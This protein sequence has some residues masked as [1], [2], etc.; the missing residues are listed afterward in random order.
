MK[1][2]VSWL[3]GFL[4][5][6]LALTCSFVYSQTWEEYRK[7]EAEN[8]KKFK[9]DEEAY[10]AGMRKD[11]QDYVDKRDK[12]YADFLK[13]G[14]KPYKVKEPEKQPE[15]PK[16]V[17]VPEYVA[18]SVPP[19]ETYI[20][21][22][23]KPVVAAAP[24]QVAVAVPRPPVR[25]P[26]KPVDSA[27]PVSFRFYD[28]PVYLDYDRNFEV[29]VQPS[30][31][32][33]ISTYW[34]KASKT[35]YA[36]LVEQLLA[37]K[38]Q[39]N[40]N[41]YAYY[42]L[43]NK[44]AGYL[45]PT[46]ETGQTLATW[47]LMV[48]SGYGVRLATQGN[49]IVLLIPSGSAVYGKGYLTEDGMNYYIMNDVE[50]TSLNTY[51]K[52]YTGASRP[53]DFNI[54]SPID[55]GKKVS[56]KTLK[57]DYKGKQ[58][59]ILVSF[60]PGLIRLYNDFP[61]LGMDVYF[62]A[63]VSLQLKES[64]SAS[65]KP[66]MVGMNEA[67]SVEF[68]LAFVQHA[69]AY[70]TDPEQF[71]Y[72]KFFFA[73]EVFFYPFCDCED[74]S[75]LFSYLVRDLL[76][77]DVVGLEYPEHMA[78]AVCFTRQVPGDFV[79]Y[80]HRKFVVSDPTYIG[81]PVGRTMPNF[82]GIS[83]T[84][85]PMENVRGAETGMQSL[86][87]RVEEGGCFRGSNLH[88]TIGLSDGATLMTG[89]YSGS[90]NFCGKAL[91]ATDKVNGCFVGKVLDSGKPDWFSVLTST[92]NTVGVSIVAEEKGNIF[93]AGSF[94]GNLT[95]GSLSLSTNEDRPDGFVASYTPAG[96][97][98]W[99]RKLNLD[100]I[101]VTAPVA[102]SASFATDGKRMGLMQSE[103]F[104][105]FRDY[106]LFSD[107]SGKVV[108]N[109]IVNR[110]FATTPSTVS[111]AAGV[112]AASPELLKKETDAMISDRTDRG[113]A[114]LFAAINL[115]KDMVMVLSGTDAMAALDKFNPGFRTRSPSI[116]KNIG[117]IS[118]VRNSN[119]VIS[120]LTLDGK[121]IMFDKIKV[122]NKAQLSI[123]TLSSGD[124]QFDVLSGIKVGKMVVWYDLNFIR[125]S[126][127]NGDMMFDYDSDHSQQ[128]V[129]M[130]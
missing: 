87:S 41:D 35:Q 42:L 85:I 29:P 115:V 13:S 129:N 63:A 28:V 20:P 47:F 111:F 30:G 125:L 106:G 10:L 57:F 107:G 118:F 51:D 69:F 58:H 95:A 40:L 19:R 8:F 48:R 6:I 59:Q 104:D 12:E 102:F 75:V 14:W 93:V 45:Y 114:G 96:N 11:F 105:D 110:V 64:V 17:V 36:G 119:G 116:Y 89:Y 83:P 37:Q 97:L 24:V 91:P 15:K 33:A 32:K 53:V 60:D 52:D 49:A 67:E 74:R 126:K 22:P 88:N 117:K 46:N 82:A 113:V 123:S 31:R 50:G 55:L 73:D 84:V 99:I 9:Q 44:F 5:G 90:A 122:K 94:R 16:P 54:A 72:E 26:V 79:N 18:P 130:R 34:E 81:A 3:P 100:S 103:V 108:Y 77:L 76:G 4:I 43:V 128:K 39:L 56:S 70:K 120:I 21:I 98:R 23:L 86:W 65:L 92:G 127:Q 25:R 80:D 101:P 68:L 62:N 1:K 66:M 78:T 61:Q 7:Q 38:E 124:Y 109:G 71:G 121:D 2:I 27:T 112:M